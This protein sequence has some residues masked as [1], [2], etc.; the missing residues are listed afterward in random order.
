M[1]RIIKKEIFKTI[2]QLVNF[3]IDKDDELKNFNRRENFIT[4][5]AVLKDVVVHL[6][7]GN[8]I[9]T[10]KG[11]D[12]IHNLLSIHF[13]P[14]DFKKEVTTVV[15]YK[16]GKPVERTIITNIKHF[17]LDSKVFYFSKN[18]ETCGR[19]II[20]NFLVNIQKVNFE[21]H[22]VEYFERFNIQEP[23]NDDFYYGRMSAIINFMSYFK[24]KNFQPKEEN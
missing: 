22:F 11:Y 4:M 20:H 14:F 5:T 24:S 17:T 9:H 23:T 18:N 15:K 13:L 12:T 19:E 3:S 10:L 16:K 6:C 1:K 7:E 8:K 21:A 2:N